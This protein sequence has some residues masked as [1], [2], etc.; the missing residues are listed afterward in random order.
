MS[1]KSSDSHSLPQL[2]SFYIHNKFTSLVKIVYY[3]PMQRESS[4]NDDELA[5]FLNESCEQVQQRDVKEQRRQE[6]DT[7]IWNVIVRRKMN[8]V[9]FGDADQDSIYAEG[10]LKNA[11]SEMLIEVTDESDHP[12]LELMLRKATAYRQRLEYNSFEYVR[13][14]LTEQRYP[15]FGGEEY[16]I[17]KKK[18]MSELLLANSSDEWLELA[19]ELLEGEPLDVS[20]PYDQ[21]IVDNLRKVHDVRKNPESPELK[22]YNGIKSVLG[23]TGEPGIDGDKFF[24]AEDLAQAAA[25][26]AGDDQ[27]AN[28]QER[29]QEIFRS[30]GID[31][32]DIIRNVF[33]LA[34]LYDPLEL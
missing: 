31:D 14:Y 11:L 28:R 24:I 9:I 19:D 12:A 4:F 5:S 13:L 2:R 7:H 21:Q 10:L 15:E 25:E 3:I 20:R 30:H 1:S 32:K 34:D 23:H 29:L 33:I 27:W 18:L 8:L 22:L 16:G 6:I 17:L 26:C